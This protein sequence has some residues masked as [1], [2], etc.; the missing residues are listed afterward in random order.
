[1]T[2]EN[3]EKNIAERR[4]Y[5]AEQ[6]ASF[7][8]QQEGTLQTRHPAY[9]LA[10]QD[11]DFLLRDEL[12]PVRFQL[13]LLK[14]EMLLEEANIG[15]TLVFYG[16]ARIPSPEQCEAFLALPGTD[17]EKKVAERLAAKAKYYEEARELARLASQCAVVE[18]GM[19]QF[20]VCSGGGP[21]IMEAAN[22]GAADVGAESLGLNIVLPHEQAPNPYVTP[23]LSFQFHYFALRKMH[24][25]LRAR[26]V[27]VF[28]GGFGT[29]DEFL[30]LL[31]LIQTG[32][33]KP[34]PVLLYGREFWERVVNFEALAE[35]GTISPRDLDLF[36][37][38]ET[39]KEGWDKIRAFYDLDCG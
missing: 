5:K 36:H 6:E 15:S 33:M 3:T 37:W 38:C 9:R 1:M 28:P 22:R 26:A 16:S 31:T 34:I 14:P 29:L 12:R 39:G 7:A 2:E 19:R 30:E 18:Q 35:E 23:R 20:V 32:K 17:E 27:A 25:L 10:F 21:S 11:T 4:F 24:F 13:E 8:D